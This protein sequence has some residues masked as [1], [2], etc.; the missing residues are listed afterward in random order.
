[1]SA[2]ESSGLRHYPPAATPIDFDVMRA[3]FRADAGDVSRFRAALAAYLGVG[4]CFPAASGRA[5]FY[6]LLATLRNETHDAARTEVILP[7]YT[8]PSLAKVAISAGL[9]PRLVD[10]SPYTLSYNSAEL[11][12]A[13]SARTLALVL[14]HPFGIPHPVDSALQIARDAGAIVIEDA[15]QAMGAKLGGRFVGTIGNFGLFS[16]GPGK[17]MSTAGGGFV[18]ASDEAATELL[19]RAWD[20]LPVPVGAAAKLAALR[21]GLFAAAFHPAGWWFAAKAGAQR[22]GDNEAS[23]G[24]TLKGLTPAQAGAGLALLPR[25]DAINVARRRRAEALM[26]ALSGLGEIH[27]PAQAAARGSE[28]VGGGSVAP[29]PIYLRLPLI[30]DSEAQR[31]EVYRALWKAGY[32]AGRMYRK[33]LAEHFPAYADGVYPGAE[34]VARCLLTLPTHHYLADRDVDIIAGLIHAA[35]RANKGEPQRVQRAQRTV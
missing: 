1:M 25:L 29:Q 19:R 32:G 15:A 12:T 22:I 30:L 28:S 4:A 6:L 16:L 5:A 11:A 34:Q 2:G 23:W 26:V 7:A 35:L 9:I 24:F 21:I 13:V 3:A 14:V 18:C 8:C 20:A 31:D 33:T 27:L 10:V 17:P